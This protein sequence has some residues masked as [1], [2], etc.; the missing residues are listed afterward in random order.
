MANQNEIIKSLLLKENS[1]ENWMMVANLA[2]ENKQS[3]LALMDCFFSDN[4]RLIQRSSQCLSKIHD[5]DPNHLQRYFSKMIDGIVP[6][7]IDAYKRNVM[8]IFQDAIIPIKAQGK[9]F[10]IALG[11]LL[12]KGEAIAIQAFSMTVLKQICVQHPELSREVIDAIQII[13]DDNPSKGLKYRGLKEI[14]VLEKL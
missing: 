11:F 9:L 7:S 13:L 14:K 4:S 6:N 2:M 12:N 1:K 5:L 8:R 3:L 10:D